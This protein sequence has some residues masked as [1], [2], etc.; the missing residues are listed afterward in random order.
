MKVGRIITTDRSNMPV[1]SNINIRV[2]YNMEEYRKLHI[3]ANRN[4]ILSVKV[5]TIMP[6]N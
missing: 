2:G 6:N 1:Q 3:P 5:K 4:I